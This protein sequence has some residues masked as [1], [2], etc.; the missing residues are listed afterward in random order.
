M[1][2]RRFARTAALTFAVWACTEMGLKAQQQ[3]RPSVP[4][5]GSVSAAATKFST[6]TAL[7][8][9][10]YQL[11]NKGSGPIFGTKGKTYIERYFEKPLA[12]LIWKNIVGPPSGEVGNLDFD[13]LFFSQDLQP[14]HLRIGEAHIERDKAK[15][16]S[17]VTFR[18]YDQQMRITFHLHQTRDAG[19]KIHD[20]DYG[21][22]EHLVKI[23]SQPF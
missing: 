23:L 13:P 16:S 15:A 8:R 19:W 1:T 7:V 22:G 21:K 6:P 3:V 2:Q 4:L 20:I 5:R 18:N 12:D 10:L 17:V 14:T 9:S 11:H